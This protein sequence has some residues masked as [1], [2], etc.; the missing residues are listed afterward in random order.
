MDG[1][2]PFSGLGLAS[3]A[4]GFVLLFSILLSPHGWQWWLDAK[5][6]HGNET[7][8]IVLYSFNGQKWSVDDPHS[9]TRSG[10][11]TVYVI[12]AD[13]ANAA[14]VNTPTVVLDWSATVGPALVGIGLL[15]CGFVSRSRRR[16]RQHDA[17]EGSLDSF[18]KGLP[19]SVVQGIVSARDWQDRH[20]LG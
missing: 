9:Q 19:S 17:I 8:G 13:P 5:A 16:R 12:A 3:L 7:N 6:V 18:G 11:R 10:P 2:G 1:T 4:V 15:W 20:H 14:L